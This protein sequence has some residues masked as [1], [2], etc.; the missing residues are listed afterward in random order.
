[1]FWQKIVCFV[2][3]TR[4]LRKLNTNILL[5]LI[6]ILCSSLNDLLSADELFFFSHQNLVR[7][8]YLHYLIILFPLD[9]RK[10][11]VKILYHTIILQGWPTCD[12]SLTPVRN[13]FNDVN[14]KYHQ[15]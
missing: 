11:I 3:Y 1:M 6:F 15:W 12:S 9:T 7:L 14:K 4:V 10:K 5:I 2:I 8:P 13:S